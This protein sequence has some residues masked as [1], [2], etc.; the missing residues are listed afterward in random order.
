MAEIPFV[1]PFICTAIARLARTPRGFSV[2]QSNRRGAM[3]TERRSRNRGIHQPLNPDPEGNGRKKAQKLSMKISSQRAS[4]SGYCSA[5]ENAP[6]FSLRASR[7]C[8]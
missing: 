2:R 5:E 6:V 3:H 4:K 7:L 8:G 1:S